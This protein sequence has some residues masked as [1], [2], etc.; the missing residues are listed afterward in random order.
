MA[1]ISYEHIADE[2]LQRRFCSTYA[3]KPFYVSAS[4]LSKT[5]E[6]MRATLKKLEI[7]E[8]DGGDHSPLEMKFLF[9]LLQ[10]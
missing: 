8:R 4:R 9:L 3:A 1:Q 10:D 6:P 2:F 7:E 5:C